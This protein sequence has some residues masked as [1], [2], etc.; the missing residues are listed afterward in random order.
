VPNATYYNVQLY[1]DGKK[2]L[3]A[4]PHATQLRL[5]A[6]WTF[7]GRKYTLS[8]GRYRWY[9]WPGY[10][11]LSANRYGKLIGTRSFVVTGP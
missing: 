6:S 10:G 2:I 3:T 9:V 4:W 8:P 1:H 7:D 11:S 5:Q